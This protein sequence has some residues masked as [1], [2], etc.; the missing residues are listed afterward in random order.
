M[1]VSRFTELVARY[2]KGIRNPR[3]QV[4]KTIARLENADDTRQLKARI[5]TMEKILAEL[6]EKYDEH[7]HAR[8]G[9]EP[10]KEFQVKMDEK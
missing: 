10:R 4:P 8:R 9:R 5:N 3:C 1:N 2:T 6:V 7:W